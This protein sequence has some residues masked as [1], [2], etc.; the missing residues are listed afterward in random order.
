MPRRVPRRQ[1]MLR[2]DKLLRMNERVWVRDMQVIQNR[3]LAS[4]PRS[5][6]SIGDLSPVL[7]TYQS[8]L[9]M[10]I[11]RN[12][13][14]TGGEFAQQEAEFIQGQQKT[15]RQEYTAAIQAYYSEHALEAAVTVT[16]TLRNKFRRTISQA[17]ERGRPR[18]RREIADFLTDQTNLTRGEV[19]RIARTESHTA[20]QVGS[21]AGAVAT[22]LPLMKEWLSA[23]NRVR[24]SHLKADGQKRKLDEPYSVGGHPAMHPGDPDLPARERINCRCQESYDVIE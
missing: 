8:N 12:G 22:G 13:V 3:V 14:R 19:L 15:L 18:S 20:S 21:R 23:E 4:I 11:E 2:K 24:P 9:R 1:R 7:R 17:N 5:V 6:G 10:M 16:D